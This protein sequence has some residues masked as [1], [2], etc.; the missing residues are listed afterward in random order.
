MKL[1]ITLIAIGVIV[2]LW[3]AVY[4]ITLILLRLPH[5]FAYGE[6]IANWGMLGISI[7]IALFCGG[8]PLSYGQDR[9]RK[10]KQNRGI[11]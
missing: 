5:S 9:I 6:P 8:I 11:V 10:A 1:G 3:F 2:I 7:A 4:P